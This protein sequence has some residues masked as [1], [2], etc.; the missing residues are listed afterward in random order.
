MDDPVVSGRDDYAVKAAGLTAFF[1][2]HVGSYELSRDA[3]NDMTVMFAT[4]VI[5][6]D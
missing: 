3:D 4:I 6:D 2:H 5:D 1:M